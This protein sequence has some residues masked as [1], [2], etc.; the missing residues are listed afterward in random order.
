MQE[1]TVLKFGGTSMGDEHTWR[2]VLEIIKKYEHPVVVVSATARTTRKLV[3]AAEWAPQ[4]LE[5]SLETADEISARHKKLVS[6]LLSH[7]EGEKT[8]A[9]RT[10]CNQW[11]DKQIHELQDYLRSAN[12]KK[13]I[14]ESIKDAISSVGERL[15]SFLLAACAPLFGLSTTWIDAGRIITTDSQFGSANPLPENIQANIKELSD[16]ISDHQ[17]PVIGGYYGQDQEGNITTL[18]F[19]GS[20]YTAS[21]IGAALDASGIE[22]W[23]DVSGIFSCD[24]R[25]VEN[26]KPIKELSF[27]EAT[28]LAY[29]GAKVLHPSTMKPASKKQIPIKVKNIFEA[30]H[31]GTIIYAAAGENGTAKALTFIEEATIITIQASDSTKGHQFLAHVFEILNSFHLPVDVVTTTE[32]SVSLA[33]ASDNFDLKLIEKLDTIG[34]IQQT[35]S[36]SIISL[37][38][39]NFKHAKLIS[40]KV[41]EAISGTD[42]AI[43]SYSKDKKNLNVVV[44]QKELIDAVKSIH[45]NIFS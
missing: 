29:F 44:S 14:T 7:T 42:I 37:I 4:N 35:H 9:I 10:K 23:T 3:E 34:D 24:P 1:L 27:T 22:I 19:E 33:L 18:G 2:K 28:E 5:K 32:A 12:K 16:I 38:G 26:A 40:D 45:K 20:D 6:N 21:L 13:E 43:M 39:C 36:Q 31:A 25:V 30:D 17:I 8:D 41:L 15:S 11:I